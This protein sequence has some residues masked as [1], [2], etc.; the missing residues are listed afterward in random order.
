MGMGEQTRNDRD[1]IQ[2]IL[3]RYCRGIDRL[4]EELVRSC[5]HPDATDDHGLYTG[6]VDSFIRNAFERQRTLL[7]AC[8][9]LQ[10]VY[11]EVEGNV[12]ASEAYAVAVER[13]SGSEGEI[14]DN[15]AGV[16]YVDRFERRANGPWLIAR[17]TVVLDWSRSDVAHHDWLAGSQFVRGTRDRSDPSY[18]ELGR[19]AP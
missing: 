17:R 18:S 11:I 6:V 12:A 10:N 14:I 19:L 5:Y 8:H 1:E 4:D 13:T 15:V 9:Y 16:R 2:Q 3:L 7:L